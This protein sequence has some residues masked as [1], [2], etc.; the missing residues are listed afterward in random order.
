METLLV[1]QVLAI[2]SLKFVFFF[3]IVRSVFIK[4]RKRAYN[5]KIY[6]YTSTNKA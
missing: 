1:V 6:I 3:T 2:T 5:Y 4:V